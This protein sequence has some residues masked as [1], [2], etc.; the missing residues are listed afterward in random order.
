MSSI[1]QFAR[2]MMSGRF[3]VA[4]P[5]ANR[6]SAPQSPD[7]STAVASWK[8]SSKY[9]QFRALLFKSIPGNHLHCRSN[10][11]R[12]DSQNTFDGNFTRSLT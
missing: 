6:L 9:I 3:H 5:T 12:I 8:F 4:V 11:T 1:S 2:N 10:Y 7:R